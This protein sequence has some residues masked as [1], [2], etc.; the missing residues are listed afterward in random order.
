MSQLATVAD[1]LNKFIDDVEY[2]MNIVLN[3]LEEFLYEKNILLTPDTRLMIQK[4]VA[5]TYREIFSR[6]QYSID[7]FLN[8]LVAP[9]IRR[10]YPGK[11]YKKII[12]TVEKRLHE[13][14][15]DLS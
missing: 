4:Y 8:Y 13:L 11:K 10:F 2:R 1:D 7:V 14:L 15:P 6:K 5:I 12:K 9:V 3:M